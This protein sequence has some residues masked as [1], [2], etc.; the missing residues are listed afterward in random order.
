VPFGP[1]FRP[2]TCH[3]ALG[4]AFADPVEAAAFPQTIL[5]YRNERWAQRVGL[6]ALTNDEWTM[7]FG[8]F[9]PLPGSFPEPLAL[10][11][12]GHQFRSYNP[13]LGDG[14]GFLFAQLRDD[15]DRLLDLG[16]KGS[17]QTPYSRRGDGRLTLKG[18]V[19]EVLATAMLEALGVETSKSFSL[20]E[21]GEA[22]HRHDEP[23]PTRSSV[24]VRLSHSHIRIG[25]FQRLR[26]EGD[27]A[28][29]A[30]LVT[31]CTLHYLPE[32]RRVDMPEAV[33][34]LLDAVCQR[35]A[36]MSAQ[37]FAAGFVH[38]VLNTDNINITGESFDYGPYRFLPFYDPGFTAAYF[39]Q[40]GLYAFGRQADTIAWNLARLAE[41]LLPL[42]DQERLQAILESFGD[43]FW[44]SLRHALFRRLGISSQTPD[45]DTALIRTL[46][47]ALRESRAP[48]EAVMFDLYGGLARLDK[49][50]KGPRSALYASAPFEALMAAWMTTKPDPAARLDA[51]YFAGDEPATLLYDEIEALW[52]PIAERDDWSRFAAKLTEIDQV[53]LAYGF[54]A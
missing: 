30:R 46:F 18:G 36:V 39:D 37:W 27:T 7:H 26:A 12:H 1:R 43:R 16:T 25:T 38:G 19:R 23:S 20:I 54:A 42:A 3:A 28:S 2:E 9:E 45:A 51:R 44:D 22:L 32:A 17:G 31:H 13:D 50:R 10:R 6:D 47:T 41:C 33:L 15:T 49:A 40:T 11:Y 14:R 21:T 53:R 48:F 29:I 34:A 52:A 4:A 35:T 8:R 24:L 5:R